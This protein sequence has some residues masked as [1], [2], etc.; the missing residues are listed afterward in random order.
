MVD[1][2]KAIGMDFSPNFEIDS[3]S[4]VV[5][6]GDG[7]N[8]INPGDSFNF[9]FT[10]R[11]EVNWST[12]Y[13]IEINVESDNSNISI[14]NPS[15]I[16]PFL[17]SGQTF[18]SSEL[19][20][21]NISQ[22][23][24]LNDIEININISATGNDNFSYNESLSLTIPVS[25]YQSGFP[26]TTTSQISSSP[27]IIDLNNDGEDEIIFGDFNGNVHILNANGSPIE[28]NHF[29]YD[30]GDQIWGSPAIA[31]IDLD[32]VLDIIITS[33]SK[34]LY[35]FDLSLIHI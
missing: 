6:S 18:T 15:F 13:N 21:M 24:P 5:T 20:E 4:T 35:V 3:F 25:L 10:L 7:D 17:E 30:T 26:L 23:A 8:V 19:I 16:I 11:N 33:K 29:P 12:A 9:F 14:V 27:S 32:G 2:Y 31:D 34:H 22:D 1:V 28:S